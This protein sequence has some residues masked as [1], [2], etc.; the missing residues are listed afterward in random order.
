MFSKKKKVEH[1]SHHGRRITV[2]GGKLGRRYADWN[3]IIIRMQREI[4][5]EK[6][7]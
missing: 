6:R 7:F 1:I 4:T 2:K 5:N 3:L